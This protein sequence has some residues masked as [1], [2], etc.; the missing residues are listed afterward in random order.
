M[1]NLETNL[2]TG[3]KYRWGFPGAPEGAGIYRGRVHFADDWVRFETKKTYSD[4]TEIIYLN[5]RN[6]NVLAPYTEES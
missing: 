6:L 1:S 5:L 2:I 3:R 4:D